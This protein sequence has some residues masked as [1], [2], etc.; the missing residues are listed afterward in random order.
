MLVLIKLL[1]FS[2][3]NQKVNIYSKYSEVCN[4]KMHTMES[5]RTKEDNLKIT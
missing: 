5:E 4:T 1:T 3:D 2:W